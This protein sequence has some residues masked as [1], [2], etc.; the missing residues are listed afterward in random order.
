MET[1]MMCHAVWGF[2]MLAVLI[3]SCCSLAGLV[4]VPFLSHALYHRI[5]MVFEGLAVG[6][7]L[8][9]AVFH[10]IPQMAIV[11]SRCRWFALDS[12]SSVL[13]GLSFVLVFVASGKRRNRYPGH[14]TMSQKR[15]KTSADCV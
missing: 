12:S 3:I 4:I 1:G 6:S 15:D 7:L 8:G 5:L 2:G 11:P 9:S 13:C 10:L 14:G